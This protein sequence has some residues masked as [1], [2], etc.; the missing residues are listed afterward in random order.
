MSKTYLHKQKGK[1]KHGI[2]GDEFEDYPFKVRKYY[3]RHCGSNEDKLAK[4]EKIRKT[5]K[6]KKFSY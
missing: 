2:Y 4:M 3:D 6:N 5:E 1:S